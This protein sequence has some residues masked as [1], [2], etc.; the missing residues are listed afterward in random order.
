MLIIHLYS[1][2]YTVNTCHHIFYLVGKKKITARGIEGRQNSLL[3]KAPVT[4]KTGHIY[5]KFLPHNEWI[6]ISVINILYLK[7]IKTFQEDF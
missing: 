2:F 5:I 1:L 7:R 6:E 4:Y 3:I